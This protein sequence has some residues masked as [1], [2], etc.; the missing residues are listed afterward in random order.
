MPSYYDDNYGFY[1]IESQDDVDFYFERQ[2]SNV[3]KKC[4][5]CGRKVRIQPDYVICNRC[6]D[7]QEKGWE[8]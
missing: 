3:L 8:Y 6:A 2:R 1:E 5:G 7:A 4:K